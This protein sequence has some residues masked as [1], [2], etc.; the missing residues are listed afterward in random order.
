MDVPPNQALCRCFAIKYSLLEFFLCVCFRRLA[1]SLCK[2][3]SML[4]H[5]D[6]KESLLDFVE[7]GHK[8]N[9]IITVISDA[10]TKH[11]EDRYA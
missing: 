2:Y 9:T 1:E 10:V 7:L 11:L 8:P 4:A 5:V 3:H 6:V